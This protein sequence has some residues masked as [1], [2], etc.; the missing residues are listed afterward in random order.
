[1]RQ[2]KVV[3]LGVLFCLSA[4]NYD[5]MGLGLCLFGNGHGLRVLVWEPAFDGGGIDQLSADG[6][7][8][9]RVSGMTDAG[10]LVL[11]Y[12]GPLTSGRLPSDRSDGG[13]CGL[14]G[15]Y[16][17]LMTQ[18]PGAAVQ[19][20]EVAATVTVTPHDGGVLIRCTQMTLADGGVVPDRD[21]TF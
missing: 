12:D 17:Y 11:S 3:I 8:G 20:V 19:I 4:C 7:A 2:E 10:R 18:N 16:A 6:G 13:T 21:F 1:M 14:P 9:L 5:A 15:D